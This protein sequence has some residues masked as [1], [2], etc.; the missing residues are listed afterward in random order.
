MGIGFNQFRWILGLNTWGEA[1]LGRKLWKSLLQR[2]QKPL[3]SLLLGLGLLASSA[4]LGMASAV[5]LARSPEQPLVAVRARSS[6]VPIRREIKQIKDGIY[7]YGQSSKP[8]QYGK[9]YMVFETKNGK[10]IGAFYIPGSEFS[11][12]YGS[13]DGSG[14]DLNVVDPFDRFTYAHSIAL[15]PNSLL[16]SSNQ[17]GLQGYQRVSRLGSG[18]RRLLAYCRNNYRQHFN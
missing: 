6:N 18:D 8:Q 12:F 11:C 1:M 3:T 10:A 14:M 13:I 2:N 16:A 15:R 5:K 17:I 4:E 7:V 9:E